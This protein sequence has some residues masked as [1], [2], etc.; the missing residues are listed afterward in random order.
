[1]AK[2]AA[3][4]LG[5]AMT[6]TSLHRR[7]L[8]AAA[9]LAVP[10]LAL[11]TLA[12]AQTPAPTQAGPFRFKGFQ[13]RDTDAER[14]FFEVPEDRRDPRSR[15]IRLS[16]VRFASTAAKPGPPIVYLAG[17]P[18]GLA[19]RALA[20][21]RFPIMMAL[22]EVADV[23]AFD[24]RGTGL[25]NHIPERPVSKGPP[26]AFTQAGLTAYFREDFQN[27][28]ADW[29]KAGIAM[30]GYNTEQNADD[31]DDLR[32][33]LGA[34]K[35]DLWGISYG[36]HLALSMLKRHGD[37]VSRV[38]LASLEGQDQTVKRPAAVDTLLRQVDGL[39][40]ADP[41]VRAAIPDLPALMRRVHAK[42]EAAPVAI[43][44]T[45]NG[46]PVTL[47]IGG[48]AIQLM[49]GGLIANPQTLVMLPGL[50]LALDAGRTEVLT[51]FAN[52]FA[53]LLGI[54]GMPEAM[55]LA[56]GISPRRLAQ[57]RREAKTAVLGEALNFPMPQL[58]GAVPGVDLG[59]DFRAPLRIDHPAL[60]LA[61]TL[62]GRTP[63][64][65]QDEV[66]AQFRR[67]SRVI[68]ENAGHNVFE[69]HPEVQ[70]L[71]VRFFRGEAVSD[72]RLSL[73]PPRFSLA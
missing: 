6:H 46:A 71:L 61:G 5:V 23:I 25:S 34:D 19:T 7:A 2:G 11:P 26:P 42:L 51:R 69:A 16:Y 60:L 37:R 63:M 62:D 70:D 10:A 9:G 68:V 66:A 15:K 12:F 31:I 57:V 53:N 47:R 38:A 72:T 67:K 30:T 21:P 35:V 33:H 59:E 4:V 13:G 18:G 28:W 41:A 55:D 36:T 40:A 8:L 73:P 50:Y 45:L 14:G 58:L 27:A 1:M 20:G 22:R 56:S 44:A 32:R 64:S 3:R 43:T 54:A 48:F 17:G 29:T 39:L 52:E 49:T 65:E 24:Q